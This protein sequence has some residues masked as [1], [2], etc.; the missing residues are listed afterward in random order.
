[1][2]IQSMT[3]EME[4]RKWSNSPFDPNACSEVVHVES[5][6]LAVLWRRALGGTGRRLNAG[7]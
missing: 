5:L 6:V 2:P 3:K 7:R 4:T 1:M